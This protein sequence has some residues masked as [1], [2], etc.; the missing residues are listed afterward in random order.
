MAWVMW[1]VWNAFSEAL[2]HLKYYICRLGGGVGM[3]ENGRE[4][5]RAG[6]W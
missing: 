1:I 5:G 2:G 4:G 6:A 3:A